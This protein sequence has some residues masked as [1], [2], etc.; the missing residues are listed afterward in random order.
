MH[1]TLRFGRI[2]GVP[3]GVHWSVAA[4][5]VLV[6]AVLGVGVLPLTFPD[7]PATER[8]L[9]AA[10]GMVLFAL[11]LLVHE[12]GHAL[13]ARRHGVGVDGVTLWALGGV[14]RLTGQAP[15]PSAEWRIAAAGPAASGLIGLV[16]AGGAIAT[17]HGEQASAGRAV[18]LWVGL[19]NVALAVLNLL[20]GA[21]LDGG[22]VLTALVWKRTGDAERARLL[23]GRSGLL[24]GALL[25]ALG[26]LEVLA[27][28]RAEGWG[29]VAV[30]AF[31]LV[32]ARSE[33]A[34]AVVR[35]RLRRTTMSAVMTPHPPGV[36]DSLPV[37]RFLPWAAERAD[38]VFPV[39]RWDHQPV[40]WV[41]YDLAARVPPPQRSW[42]PVGRAMVPDRQAPRA[43]SSE[44]VDDV[45]AR[46]SDDLPH[47][48]VVLD[49]VSGAVVGTVSAA[50]LHGLF[51]GPDLWGREP[52]VA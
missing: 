28:D 5:A 24:L 41:S 31:L 37:D 33:I 29:T 26:A 12:F 49:P 39:Q 51:R 25:V 32:S 46:L 27:W 6:T 8:W 15:T 36:P 19:V 47:L 18:V 13:V 42:T 4:M 9:A 44:P 38:V 48:V 40:G 2:A 35:A 11:S 23:S 10:A 21:P 16:L 30:G 3:V 14:A 50:R 22:R 1:D 34:G 20:P 52:A 7:Q 43:W 45:L 17:R